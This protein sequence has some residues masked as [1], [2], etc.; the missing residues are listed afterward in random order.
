MLIIVDGGGWPGNR[1]ILLTFPL[2]VRAVG[3]RMS[4]EATGPSF[5]PWYQGGTYYQDAS[6]QSWQS[7]VWDVWPAARLTPD[8]SQ[9]L[10]TVTVPA[11]YTAPNF[12]N[13]FR[14]KMTRF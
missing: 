7:G 6:N 13:F 9:V 12:R 4:V 8:G 14:L 10:I 5:G 3:V 1:Q 2:N 11:S